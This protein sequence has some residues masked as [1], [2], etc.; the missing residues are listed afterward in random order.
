MTLLRPFVDCDDRSSSVANI[1]TDG[2]LGLLSIARPQRFPRNRRS[3]EVDVLSSQ[4]TRPHS[5]EPG[6]KRG[7][8]VQPAPWSR[9]LELR[10]DIR[11][12]VTIP[13]HSLAEGEDCLERI[14]QNATWN[15]L[16]KQHDNSMLRHGAVLVFVYPKAI[17]G[18]GDYGSNRGGFQQQCGCRVHGFPLFSGRAGR[19]EF[20]KFR[21]TRCHA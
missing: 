7:V 18:L 17:V 20:R 10:I 19:S 16:S 9:A 21:E 4:E 11:H 12:D 1:P 8:G 2:E 5:L 13:V 15:N 3:A 14:A 6:A